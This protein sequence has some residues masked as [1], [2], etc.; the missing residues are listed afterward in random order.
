MWYTWDSKINICYQWDSCMDI[1]GDYG[2]SGESA[3]PV[4][5]LPGICQEIPNGHFDGIDSEKD[6]EVISVL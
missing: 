5:N 2:E 3:C 4:C 1:E 6:C